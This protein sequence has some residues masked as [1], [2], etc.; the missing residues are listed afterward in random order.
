MLRNGPKDY[1]GSIWNYID[2]APTICAVILMILFLNEDSNQA[3][4][5]AAR[6]LT[7]AEA[8]DGEET[9]IK[10]AESDE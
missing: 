6:M 5:Q 10:D 2:L 4:T 1:F 8:T 7:E 3:A 9:L